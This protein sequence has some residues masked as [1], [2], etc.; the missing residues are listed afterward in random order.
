MKRISLVEDG[1]EDFRR[2]V[3]LQAKQEFGNKKL[4]V[5][6]VDTPVP[7]SG[8]VLVRVTAAPI[9]PSDYGAW[10]KAKLDPEKPL[11]L[12][13][14][15]SGIVVKSGGGMKANGLL[16]T[17][18]GITNMKQGGSYQEYVCVSALE[19]A[20]PLPADVPVEDGCSFFVN[21]YTAVGIVATAKELGS[22]GFCAHSSRQPAGSDACETLRSG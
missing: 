15:G 17:N 21:P 22:P 11:Y 9:N 10:M 1:S 2:M 12:G 13:N 7:K 14:E 3:S 19:G 6:E 20:F 5:E 16:G 8:E 4:V 18:V